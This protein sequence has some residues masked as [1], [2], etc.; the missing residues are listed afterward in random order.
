MF[1]LLNLMWTA[2]SWGQLPP[3]GY[4]SLVRYAK[5]RV[6]H[7]PGMPGMFSPPLRVSMTHVPWCMPGSLTTG[8][9][10]SRWRGNILGIPGACA[11]RNFTYLVRGPLSKYQKAQINDFHILNFIYE[12]F[13]T[14]TYSCLFSRIKQTSVSSCRYIFKTSYDVN[15]DIWWYIADHFQNFDHKNCQ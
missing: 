1:L 10:W 11:T 14:Y 12:K 3:R 5:L 8:F 4:G 2:R 9:L 6:A 15:N 7:A 13:T